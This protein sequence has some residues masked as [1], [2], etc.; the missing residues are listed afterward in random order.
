MVVLIREEEVWSTIRKMKNKKAVRSDE[1]LVEVWKILISLG[2]E[3]LAK[4]FNKILVLI[5]YEYIICYNKYLML[6]VRTVAQQ[7][8]IF[9]SRGLYHLP[10]TLPRFVSV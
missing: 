9:H 8:I 5:K 10:H 7:Q 2:I 6:T 4:F 1:I 3:W